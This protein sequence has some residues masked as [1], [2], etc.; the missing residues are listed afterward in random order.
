M[1]RCSKWF[2]F[3]FFSFL[4]GTSLRAQEL[5]VGDTL[6]DY[7]FNSVLRYASSSSVSLPGLRG[8][9]LVLD[10]WRTTCGAAVASFSHFDSLRR[11]FP[12]GLSALAVTTESREAIR[13]YLQENSYAARTT[14]PV[15][16]DDSLLAGK[17][18]KFIYIPHA[19]LVDRKGVI[20][21]ITEP[22]NITAPVIRDLLDGKAIHLPLKKEVTDF[23]YDAPIL[24]EGG[25][26]NGGSLAYCSVITH[27]LPGVMSVFNSDTARN[28]T[29][30]SAYNQTIPQL[31][32]GAYHI[33]DL[34]TNRLIL[35]VK[36]ASRFNIPR[37]DHN[38]DWQ[39]ENFWCYNLILPSR[40]PHPERY[41]IADF[42]RFFG[43]HGMVEKRKVK[44]L[45]LVRKG[46]GERW[47]SAG[48]REG[49]YLDSGGVTLIHN[50]M[51]SSV[52]EAWDIASPLPILDR[53]GLDNQQA[54]MKVE[55]TPANLSLFR[56]SLAKYDLDV[57]ESV[58][59]VEMLVIREGR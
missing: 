53:T 7:T 50:I 24:T 10:L 28:Q 54:D 2:C 15:I 21:A 36:D 14:M 30:Y 22:G 41:A 17:R 4:S 48:G 46:K 6:P 33:V 42:D 29:F 40:V 19:V 55:G 43:V 9:I 3:L 38:D 58:E 39:K 35:Q 47:K 13:R 5:S 56:Q 57:I 32:A 44:C 45:L 11:Q 16:T 52:L 34:K 37:Y 27:R 20:V 25:G 18:F 26:R 59:E 12:D 23:D 49:Y 31:Y 51:M 8:R 1:N